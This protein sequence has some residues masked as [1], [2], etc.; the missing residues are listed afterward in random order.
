MSFQVGIYFFHFVSDLRTFFLSGDGQF[1]AVVQHEGEGLHRVPLHRLPAF[2]PV[3]LPHV[4]AGGAHHLHHPLHL[5]QLHCAGKVYLPISFR[6]SII[7]LI[8]ML[9]YLI[10][11]SNFFLICILT[12]LISSS[13]I[14]WATA[15]LCEGMLT[16]FILL[17]RLLVPHI[18]DIMGL[19]RLS[20]GG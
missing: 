18:L 20:R 6:F 13:S 17:S 16:C 3:D 15:L 2:L 12:Y 11:I 10:S 8:G 19:Q 5:G 14:P 7:F 4:S 9:I 1:H